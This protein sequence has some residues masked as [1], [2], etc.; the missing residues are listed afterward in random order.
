MAQ[1]VTSSYLA[2]RTYG[3]VLNKEHVTMKPNNL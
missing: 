1:S 3:E 2:I